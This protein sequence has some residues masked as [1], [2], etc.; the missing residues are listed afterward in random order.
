MIFLL[1]IRS[2]NKI[3]ANI[4]TKPPIRPA[5]KISDVSSLYAAGKAINSEAGIK[6]V[7]SKLTR[8]LFV[9][10]DMSFNLPRIKPSKR[11][12][13]IVPNLE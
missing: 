10:D 4:T 9:L 1:K 3:I 13:A 8:S 12:I 11:I 6:T 2:D 7:R 5:R